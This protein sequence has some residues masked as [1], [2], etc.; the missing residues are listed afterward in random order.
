M[1]VREGIRKRERERRGKAVFERVKFSRHES[2]EGFLW[3][4]I[5]VVLGNGGRERERERGESGE[6]KEG[7]RNRKG[8][9]EGEGFP[10]ESV[11]E[12]VM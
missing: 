1:C 5:L 8:G 3:Y 11:M 2:E 12:C 10:V 9:R 4:Q 7:G 6:E